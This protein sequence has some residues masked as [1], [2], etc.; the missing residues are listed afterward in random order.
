MDG[1]RNTEQI[2]QQAIEA[3]FR[4]AMALETGSFRWS[5]VNQGDALCYMSSTEPSILINRVMKLGSQYRPTLEQLSN[6]RSL[7]RMAGL[8][9]FFLHVI[10]EL[11]GPD[12]AELLAEAGYER[13]RGWMKFSRG[14]GDVNPITSDLSIRRI[15]PDDATAFASI[16][17]DA[18]DFSADFQPAIAALVHDDNWHVYMSF[19]GDIPAGTGA[20]YMRDGLGYLDFGAT[21]PDFRRRGSQSAILNERIRDALDAGCTSVVTMTGEA[22]PGD[23]QHSYRNI[24]KAGFTE[25]YLRENWIPVSS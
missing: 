4:S 23:E 15:G 20:L 5:R 12:Y 24:Q 18:F 13:Y 6:I 22:V 1:V 11:L 3:W 21:H 17:G 25:A 19:A 10:P 9:R 7:Y 14:A 2:E 8:S 16:V